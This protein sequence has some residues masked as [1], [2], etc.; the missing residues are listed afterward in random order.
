M[1]NTTSNGT[2]TRAPRNATPI[3][4]TDA[5]KAAVAAAVE[6]QLAEATAKA[7]AEA[8]TKVRHESGYKAYATKEIAPAIVAYMV[9]LR[10][11]FPELELG[12]D[13]SR[14]ARLVQVGLKAYSWFQKSDISFKKT[15]AAAAAAAAPAP[16][17]AE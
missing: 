7:V 5:F 17:P 15:K 8:T 9:W 12:D 3:E 11:E 10:R 13:D 14:D 1:S 4:E 6:A 16:A 2:R